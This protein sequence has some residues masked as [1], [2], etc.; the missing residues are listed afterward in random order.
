M[1]RT[2]LDM[3]DDDNDWNNTAKAVPEL[4]WLKTLVTG[5]S[6]VMGFGMIAIVMLLWVRL[7]QPMLPD[8]PETITLPAGTRMQAVTFAH[9]WIVVV[10]DTGEVLLYDRGG[11]LH[12]RVQSP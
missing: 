1:V 4:R 10:T 12:Q 7:D 2:R 8:L 11:K 5:L 3:G 6:L 9:N